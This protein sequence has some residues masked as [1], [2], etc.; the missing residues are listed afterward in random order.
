[1]TVKLAKLESATSCEHGRVSRDHVNDTVVIVT[2]KVPMTQHVCSERPQQICDGRVTAIARDSSVSSASAQP[3]KRDDWQPPGA[4]RA[5]PLADR[6]GRACRQ[7]DA[8]ERGEYH[9]GLLTA[10]CQ[11]T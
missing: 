10:D 2:I 1:V 11:L 9:C 8:E 4:E 5:S 7:P 3:M 6:R